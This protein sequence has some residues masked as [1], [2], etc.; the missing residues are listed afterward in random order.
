VL[1][2]IALPDQSSSLRVPE[3]PKNPGVAISSRFQVSNNCPTFAGRKCPAVAMPGSS[4]Y[5]SPLTLPIGAR[6]AFASRLPVLRPLPAQGSCCVTVIVL[7]SPWF[8]LKPF[9]SKS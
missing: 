8:R 7:F 3:S 4:L 9:Q 6:Q 1:R 5:V 2:A